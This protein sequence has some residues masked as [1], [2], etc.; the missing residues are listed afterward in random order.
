MRNREIQPELPFEQPQAAMSPAAEE[1]EVE[2][3]R[4]LLEELEDRYADAVSEYGDGD[5][6]TLGAKQKLEIARQ[7]RADMNTPE[8]GAHT[9]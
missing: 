7:R 1:P 9:G 3:P 8:S 4:D 6:R 2:K 5:R